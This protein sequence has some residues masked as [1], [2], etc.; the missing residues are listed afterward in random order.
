MAH[1]LVIELPGG[2]DGDI[3]TAA[4]LRGDRFSF[5]V[6]NLA[7]YQKQPALQDVLCR[8]DGLIELDLDD[9]T[10]VDDAVK[11]A[12]GIDR[13]DAVLCLLDIRLMD[14]ARIATLLCLPH[15]KP[16]VAF[17]LRDKF[18]VRQKLSHHLIKQ[19]NF[20]LALSNEDLKKAVQDIGLPVLIKPS[21]GF[22]SQNIAVFRDETDLAPW[23]SPLEDMLPS[24]ADYG[25]G[26]KAN[27]RLLVESYMEGQFI[28]CDFISANGQ[29]SMVGLN[30]KVMFAPP[31][32]AIKGGCFSPYDE[33]M[34]PLRDYAAHCLDAVGFDW[35]ASHIEIML[36][37]EGPRLVEINGRLVGARI[38]RLM[39]YALG[40]SVH[41]QLI[42]LLLSR[43]LPL[44]SVNTRRVAVSRWLTTSREGILDQIRLPTVQD[45]AISE[46]SLFKTHGDYVCPPYENAHRLGYVMVT[47]PTAGEANAIA[48]AYIEQCE[49]VLTEK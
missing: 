40:Y 7:H 14:A 8:A 39:S 42:T 22:G 2:N 18:S 20:R 33:T 3:L 5:L 37:R 25:L 10:A 4:L 45:P 26:V 31:S 12:H 23:L 47:A 44:H 6:A 21:D 30:E 13:F 34:A 19:P 16:D 48:D 32:F 49:V 15:I 43:A 46:V 29:H 9:H 24:R 38:P 1:L 36:T 41:E 11:T 27:D 28:G 35:G 17:L